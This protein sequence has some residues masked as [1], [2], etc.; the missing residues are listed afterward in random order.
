M[1]NA[2]DYKTEFH[3]A[4]AELIA[5]GIADRTER[6]IAIQALIDA[7]VNSIGEVPEA[8]ELERLT[9]YI[10]REELTD[11]HPD[12]MTRTE[13]PI[14][15]KYQ[16][17]R[18]R[19]N[20]YEDVLAESYDVNGVNYAKPERRHRI[21]RENRFVEKLAQRKNRARKAQYRKDTSAGPI[22]TYNLRDTGGELAPEFRQCIGIGQRWK[23]EMCV[24][25]ET[26]IV[27]EEDAR[28]PLQIAA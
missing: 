21:E 5:E 10:L 18:R 16:E 27:Q 17:D 13:Y 24:V 26:E 7:Y 20:E 15:S 19:E 9:D 14:M 23:D 12:K 1:E 25:N 4:V 6:M 28:E 11:T 8:A 2:T 22:T 3:D